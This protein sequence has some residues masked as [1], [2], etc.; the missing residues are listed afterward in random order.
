MCSEV[1]RV[2]FYGDVPDE[3]EGGGGAEF[4]E[5]V[6]HHEDG[7][8]LLGQEGEGQAAAE[9]AGEN[10]TGV[11]AKFQYMGASRYDVHKMF[12]IF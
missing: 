3:R 4:A 10:S 5:H 12:R 7:V 9:V 1:G 8:V 6:E 2:E 11:F